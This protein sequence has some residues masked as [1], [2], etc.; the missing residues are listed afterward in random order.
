MASIATEEVAMQDC[1]HTS[2]AQ[3]VAEPHKK[4]VGCKFGTFLEYK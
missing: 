3:Q 2:V 1:L 4:M